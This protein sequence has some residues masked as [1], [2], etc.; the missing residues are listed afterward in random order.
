METREATNVALIVFED[1]LNWKPGQSS[2]L[3]SKIELQELTQI[4][5]RLLLGE[6]LQYV[7]G[8]ADFYGLKFK[9]NPAV[10]IPRP[11]TEELVYQILERGNQYPWKNGLDIGTGSG[12]IPISLKKNRLDWAVTGMEVSEAALEVAI[13]NAALNKVEISWTRADVLD[14]N[15]WIDLPSYDFIVSNP[16]YIPYRE[17]EV[18]ARSVLEFEPELAL[19][20]PDDDPFL[21]Y[22]TILDLA[23]QKLNPNGGMFF[24]V[25][26][27]NAHTLID[28]VSR[29]MFNTVELIQDMQGKYRILYAQR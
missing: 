24:E 10:L 27:F 13:D 26:E 16:P 15:T 3:L 8:M 23:D 5:D 19:F 20:V 25:N 12:C 28:V 2:P 11:E 17:K 7:L 22:R 4:K 14:R 21:F 9:V 18:M 6:P 29:A 1:T